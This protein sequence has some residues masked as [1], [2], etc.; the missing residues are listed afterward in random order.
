MMRPP[1]W[2]IGLYVICVAPI[3]QRSA[4]SLTAVASDCGLGALRQRLS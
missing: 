1:T 4:V 2:I 3:R